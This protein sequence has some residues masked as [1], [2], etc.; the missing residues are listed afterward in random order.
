MNIPQQLRIIRKEKKL[1]L[2]EVSEKTG[3][4]ISYIG[5]VERGDRRGNLE[6]IKKLLDYYNYKIY[7]KKL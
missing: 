3:I 7:I 4:S 6:V 2:R 5:E 1:S